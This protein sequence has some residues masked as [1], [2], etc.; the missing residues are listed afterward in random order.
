[1]K[2]ISVDAIPLEAPMKGAYVRAR[3]AVPIRARRCLLVKI[4]TDEGLVGY[5]EGITPIAP[6]AA[7]AV[8]KHVLTPI[9]IGKD[10][11]NSEQIWESLYAINSSRGYNRGYQMI[12]ISAVD[13]ALWDLN[14]SR[15]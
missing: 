4:T 8:V 1:M 9:L 7:A 14:W 3:Q 6:Q 5:G 2:I 15:A 11:L 10:P 13:I 12:A